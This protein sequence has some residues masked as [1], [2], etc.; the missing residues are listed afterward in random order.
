MICRPELP[1]AD[2][3]ILMH[4]CMDSPEVPHVQPPDFEPGREGDLIQLSDPSKEVIPEKQAKEVRLDDLLAGATWG[5]VSCSVF[6][7]DLVRGRRLLSHDR[8][9]QYESRLQ[10]VSHILFSVD[11]QP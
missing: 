5:R 9:D 11:V 3:S 2:L 6:R 8:S 1:L 10:V 4:F 7:P